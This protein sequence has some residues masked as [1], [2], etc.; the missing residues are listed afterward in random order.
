MTPKKMEERRHGDV[1]LR[2]DTLED[3]SEVFWL[4]SGV[5]AIQLNKSQLH[6]ARKVMKYHDE[7]STAHST[8]LLVFVVLVYLFSVLVIF[9]G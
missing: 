7:F 4:Q 2:I 3:G 1:K 6:S 9:G 8:G 5:G